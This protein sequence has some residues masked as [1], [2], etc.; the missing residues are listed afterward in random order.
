LLLPPGGKAGV[1]GAVGMGRGTGGGRGE[2]GER[3][4]GRGRYGRGG[5]LR[6][7]LVYR[8]TE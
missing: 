2:G 6:R 1:R 4:Y 5:G 3:V 8:S 7:M